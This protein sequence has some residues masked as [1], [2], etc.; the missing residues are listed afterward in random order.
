MLKRGS[1]RRLRP[2]WIV[3]ILAAALVA[4]PGPEGLF[5]R[6][7][8]AK[9]ETWRQE[10]PSAFAK[11]H[12]ESVV[13][14]DNGRVRLG[15][16]VSPVGTLGAA[17]VWDLAR[18]RDGS[19]LT[20]TGDS[21]QVFRLEA[22]PGAGWTVFY[23]AADSQVL[24][25]ATTSDGTIFAGTGPKGQVV[26]LT[27]PQHPASRP[28]PKV[29]YIWD[30]AAD[31]QGN[32]FAATGPDGQL[33]KR[34]RA[35]RWTLLYDSKS[36]HLLC[37]A[38]G[39][40]GSVYAGSDGE[41]LIYRVRQDG[42]ATILFDAP[43]SDVRTLLVSPD[44]TLY[45]GTAA[46]AGS[47]GASRNSLFLTRSGP[48][49]SLE[50][51]SPDRAD[52]ARDDDESGAVRLAQSPPARPGSTGQPRTPQ[53]G[54]ASPKPI[55]PGDN[56]VYRLD[57]DGVP[58]E[59]LRVKALIHALAWLDDHLWVGTGPEGQLYQVRERGEETAPVAKLDHGQILAL[60]PEPGGGLLMGTGDPGGV[61][62]LSGQYA[63]S[64]RL[65]S[66]V[67]DTRLVSRFGTLS[68]RALQPPGTSIALQSRTGNVGEP[69]ETWSDWS[70]EQRDAAAARVASPP[71]RFVQYRATLTTTDPCG[72]R[73]YGR[74]RSATARPTW[75]PEIARLD[76]PDLSIADGAVRQTRLN[77][78]WEASDP[79]E[80]DLQFT[81][82]VR[83]EGW[84][85]WI[86]LNEA[87]ITERN[88]SWDTTTFPSGLYR[89][90]VVAS[91]RPSNN[92]DDALTRERESLSF[93]VDHD[94]PRVR[95]ESTGAGAG[96]SLADDLT[97]IVKAEYAVDGGPWT[98]MFPAD[99]LF[100]SLKEQIKLSLPH[101]SAG[102]HL[103]MVK[104]ADAAGNIGTGDAAAR[105]QGTGGE[106]I[107]KATRMP[108]GRDKRAQNHA[109]LG[110]P[111]PSPRIQQ[112]RRHR[113][114]AGGGRVDVIP[115]HVG[116][117][118]SGECP[119]RGMQPQPL[120]DRLRTRALRQDERPS[121]RDWDDATGSA[122]ERGPGRP[123][124]TGARVPR[125]TGPHRAARSTGPTGGPERPG[126]G[127]AAGPGVHL[128][129]RPQRPCRTT[130]GT[131][132]LSRHHRR[133]VRGK[134]WCVR[135]RSLVEPRGDRGARWPGLYGR[136]QRASG[137]DRWSR[138][139]NP[140]ELQD[141]HAAPVR[142]G[143]SFLSR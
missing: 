90:R 23:D 65:V 95:L 37:L 41:G 47:S 136:I 3:P 28:D 109:S 60:L 112:E 53:G 104:A 1:A 40:D 118:E 108:S 131:R 123:A 31:S 48:S 111:T 106:V 77:L 2:Q 14:S 139:R 25:L 55:S 46:E 20:A 134:Q 33:W 50:G 21:G 121:A 24:A 73:S 78:R 102:T 82:F 133:L 89:V 35:G 83:K 124:Q 120:P 71:G 10:G 4:A 100:D 19:L 85:E 127:R 32:L 43:Q 42:K 61:L 129:Q 99:E 72:R 105:G 45:A 70:P 29:Q 8:R 52:A 56:A 116:H 67:H 103:L 132:E 126:A 130:P 75:P 80:D 18:T 66:E 93:L 64:G 38:I 34:S 57:T 49:R 6:R 7:A 74:C 13:L 142:C 81:V 17:R 97:R 96:I 143:M 58:R 101:L 128:R 12:R 62:R 135:S 30:L 91:D 141:R 107:A 54:S 27:D 114:G 76:V 68:W 88:Y 15:H 11:A 140:V 92:P 94:P 51:L 86:R 138:P 63:T 98:P 79:N 59:V 84:P 125:P 115:G 26:N 119:A 44:G 22:R 36:S 110:Q 16:A 137:G 122:S 87:P 113:P 69:D 39:P 117:P 5:T 9:V